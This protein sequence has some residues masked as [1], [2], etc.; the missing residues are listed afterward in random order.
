MGD[1]SGG[2]TLDPG[3][4]DTPSD[5]NH[6]SPLDPDQEGA[7]SFE[8]ERLEREAAEEGAHRLE[9]ERTAAA[10]AAAA[11]EE[12]LQ[13]LLESKTR[14]KQN[15][16]GYLGPGLGEQTGWLGIGWNACGALKG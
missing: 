5:H 7:R 3:L 16:I 2:L 10:E 1:R 6:S 15:T 14:F 9:C 4:T 12:Q 13:W 11:A 8:H